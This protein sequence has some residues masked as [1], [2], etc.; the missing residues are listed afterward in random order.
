M[1]IHYKTLDDE[2]LMVNDGFAEMLAANG[3]ARA[4]DLW[5]IESSGVKNVVKERGTGRCFLTDISGV[6]VECYIKRY[7]PI[8]L[9]EKIKNIMSLKPYAFDAIH[10]WNALGHFLELGLNTMVPMAA[11]R[12]DNGCSCNLT[13]GITDY[14]RAS[15]LFAGFND[16]D[17]TDRR[18]RLIGKIAHMT[19]RMHA[20]GMAHQDLYLVHFFVKPDEGD[21]VYLIDLQ[22]M[23]LQP[24]LSRRWRVKDLAQLRFSASPYVSETDI[25]LFWEIY[26]EEAGIDP[27]DRNLIRDVKAKAERIRRHDKKRAARRAAGKT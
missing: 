24:Q 13:L 18:L 27:A 21:D 10:E 7:S 1:I 6:K 5:N 20:A 2:R 4:E 23:I 9:R 12:L 16:E 17:D 22:R 25:R 8:P 19:G 14:V 3:I 11:A 26:T 15:E